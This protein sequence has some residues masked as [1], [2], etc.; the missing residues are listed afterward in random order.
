[1][2]LALKS[3]GLKRQ[4]RVPAKG[5]LY[6]RSETITVITG[7]DVG[8]SITVAIPEVCRPYVAQALVRLSYLHPEM[9]FSIGEDGVT[10]ET[11]VVS[12]TLARDVSYQVYREKIYQESLP[13]RELMYKALLS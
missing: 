5:L 12:D 10:V 1:M 9:L 6:C 2:D 4:Y 7:D 3:A 8:T 11:D 13:M